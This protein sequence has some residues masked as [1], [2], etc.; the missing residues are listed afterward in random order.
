MKYDVKKVIK[1][2]F[3]IY[4]LVNL[5]A[6][7]FAHIAYLFANEIIGITLEY[8]SYYLSKSVEF[9]APPLITAI[10]FLIYRSSGRRFAIIFTLTVS[11]ARVFYSLPYYYII[12]IYNYGY[13]SI[14]AVLLSLLATLL[15]ILATSL[16]SLVSVTVYYLI[17]RLISRRSGEDTK[18]VFRYVGRAPLTD[19]LSRANLPVLTFA[20]VRFVYSFALELIDAI[21]FFIEYRQDYRPSE[22]VTILINFTLLFVLLVL[23]YLLSSAT[24]AKLVGSESESVENK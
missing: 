21:T 24:T 9:I 8:V 1:K 3:L 5:F 4:S 14:E 15:I 23:S 20:L 12:F 2:A 6:Y 19:F 18:E 10:A 22:I 13:D 11:S 7:A 16:G 17:A